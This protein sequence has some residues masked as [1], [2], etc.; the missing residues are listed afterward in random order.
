MQWVLLMVVGIV[1]AT[2][3]V[4]G[5]QEVKKLEPV[6][7]TAT[8]L[9][10]PAAELGSSVTVITE[11][12]LK[13]YHYRTIDDA[14][15]A[16]PG[17]EIR[18]SGSLG[19]TTSLTIRGANA[20]QVQVL[21]DG[22]RVKSPTTGQAEISDV[23]PELIE[24]IEVIRGPQSTLYGADAIGGVVNII[25]KKGKG[26]F[27]ATVHQEA[28]NYDTLNSRTWFSG[29]YQLLDYAFSASHLESN[30]QFQNDGFWQNAL[31]LRLGLTLPRDSSVALTLRYNRT[32]TDLPT[33]FVTTPL[34]IDPVIDTNNRQ[35]SE[36]LVTALQARTR[37][38][39]WWE[40]EL[41]LG[42]YT[43]TQIFVDRP[44]PGFD[45]AFPPC[46]F[47]SRLT[48][49]RREVE[50]LNHVH[51]GRWSTSS[52]GLEYRDE[53]GENQGGTPFHAESDTKS[54]FF[55]QQL[56]FFDRLFT[57]AGFRVEDN[58][59]FGT[60]TTERGSL[61]YLVKSWGTKLR[62]GAGSGFRAPTFN[63]LFFPGFSDRTLKPEESFSYDVGV[64]QKLW[65]NRIRLGLTYFQNEFTNLISIVS[66]ATAPF[67]KGVN[68]GKARS[69]GVEFT[70]EVD[71]LDT[72]VASVNYTYT[73]SE[74]LATRHPIPREPAHR[75]N[76]GLTWEPLRRL[77]L[78]TQVH[79]VT[80]QWEPNVVYNSGHTRV[81][82]GGS[83]RLV[84]RYAFL[85]ALDLTA[86]IQNALNEGYAE[87]RGFPA[88]GINALVGL[89]ASF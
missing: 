52:V 69:A 48:V 73:D 44:D 20:N 83:Y 40:T 26:P 74:I 19:K 70:S 9:E 88:L 4:A 66:I 55:Q 59:V 86:R 37:P 87:V 67:V 85:Q 80:Q 3:L 13:T 31:N 34:S 65:G 82:L 84:N 24:R 75:W 58:S 18:R 12:E 60:S 63:D 77:S 81:D 72:L 76:L 68:A 79:V 16:V 27:S 57:S 56:R 28:G 36:T 32:D 54:V 25:T 49:E 64:D 51:V 5:A 78:F 8:K 29:S 10:T 38:L 22:V 6:V 11:E 21:V 41:R 89:R 71:L 61:A 46:E 42:R 7:V 53:M 17:L 2:A 45:C 33:K 23:S 1:T 30:G 62:G 39:S 50:W 15:R 14:V 35:E 47:P 43:N